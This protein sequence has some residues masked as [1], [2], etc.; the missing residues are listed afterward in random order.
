MKPT[1][2]IEQAH[3]ADT[4]SSKAFTRSDEGTYGPRAARTELAS[5]FGEST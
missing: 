4:N 5:R 2:N 1:N 3:S